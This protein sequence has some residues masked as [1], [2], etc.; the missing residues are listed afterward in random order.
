[1]NKPL[2]YQDVVALDSTSHAKLKLNT[3]KQPLEFARE[4][5]LIPALIGEFGQAARDIGIAFLPAQP[6]PAVVFVCGITPDNN[7][8]VNDE[9]LWTVGYVP[10]YLRRYPFI[11]G[12][13]EGGEELLCIDQSYP[14]FEEKKG[15]ALFDKD[16]KPAEP[17]SRGLSLAKGYQEEANRTEAFA[18][19][20]VAHDLLR[21]VTLSAA[22]EGGENTSLHGLMIVDEEKLAA[23]SGEVVA[24][25]HA[26]GYLSAIYS[27]L[28]SL[29]AISNLRNGP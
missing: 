7:M 25:L 14:G 21:S 28:F 12:D 3:P 16:G 26:E 27:H 2:F 5:H 13:T 20:L 15:E 10:A 19:A 4:A 11:I 23:L 9:G 8:Y 1:M 29:H 6:H 22:S 17:I 24:K 18:A